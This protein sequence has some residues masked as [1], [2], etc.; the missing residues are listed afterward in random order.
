[1]DDEATSTDYANAEQHV[2]F[3]ATSNVWD[4][5]VRVHDDECYEESETF[6]ANL[7]SLEPRLCSE[8][9]GTMPLEITI[10]DDDCKLE[11][12]PTSCFHTWKSY[13]NV[14]LL[15]KLFRNHVKFG[16]GLHLD[17]L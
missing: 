10:T 8:V 7:D 4:A 6:H 11:E 14:I 5:Q 3:T 1:M 16:M 12:A 17:V 2:Q 13:I 9:G 15:Y